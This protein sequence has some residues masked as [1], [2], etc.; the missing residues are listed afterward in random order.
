MQF[1]AN[2]E[3]QLIEDSLSRVFADTWETSMAVSTTP[4]E[5]QQSKLRKTLLE[6]GLY[7]AWLPEGFG[8]AG[9]GCWFL[10]TM[11][12]H[13]GRN[14]VYCDHL[15]SV[16]L[17]GYLLSQAVNQQDQ[18]MALAA[19]ESSVT[20][21]LLEPNRGFETESF[22]MTAEASS[23]GY[24]I[25]GVKAYVVNAEVADL[26][27]VAANLGGK[28][29]L[30]LAPRGTEGMRVEAYQAYDGS[31]LGSVRFESAILEK[32]ALLFV[33]M[34]A[35]DM[36]NKS[37]ALAAFASS[38][39]TLGACE[40]AFEKTLDYLK[41][42]EQFGR[43]ISSFQILQHRA[44][45]L[46]TEIELLRS[47]VLG[48]ANSLEQD[49]DDQARAD[50]HGAAALAFEVGDLVGREVIQMH[51]AIG[52]TQELGIGRYLM[53]INV[54]SRLFGDRQKQLDLFLEAS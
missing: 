31:G 45:D 25:D 52:M 51:G 42:R 21:A 33:G 54:L 13:L 47:A 36:I 50:A 14:Q 15:S 22:E 7:G 12:R 37:T 18:M 19:G 17:S 27:I 11:A 23:Q 34:K 41:T 6:L 39:E 2:E 9:G 53:R 30:F 40:A 4:N 8:G 29:A 24:Q 3:Q 16:V 38:A 44:A 28:P 48:A 10:M 35:Q 5:M 32:S 43:L 20:F 26:F 1:M 49:F 46:Y